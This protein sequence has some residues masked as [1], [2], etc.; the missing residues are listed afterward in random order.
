MDDSSR[1][2]LD[3]TLGFLSASEQDTISSEIT[4]K[5]NDYIESCLAEKSKI[6]ATCERKQVDLGKQNEPCVGLLL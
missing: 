6:S 2:T 1:E 3:T 4:S 5:L